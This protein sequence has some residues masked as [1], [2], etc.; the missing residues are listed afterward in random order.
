MNQTDPAI[1]YR[2]YDADDALLYVGITVNDW[3]RVRDHRGAS[4]WWPQ[5]V[6]CTFQRCTDRAAAE[7]AETE[8]IR[9][10]NP[11]FN[12]LES[13]T[14]KRVWRVPAS[15]Y[16]EP[17]LY[18]PTR[19][20]PKCGDVQLNVRYKASTDRMHRSCGT[21]RYEWYELPVDHRSGEIDVLA[22]MP[23]EERTA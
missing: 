15:A 6:K 19:P 5:A 2:F 4:P 14:G 3:Q 13:M 17:K 8:A 18:D 22:G 7:V 10:E 11:R 23:E 16:P 1:V 21:C 12:A 20:C 9:T